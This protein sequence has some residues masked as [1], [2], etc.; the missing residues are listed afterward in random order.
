MHKAPP[1]CMPAWFGGFSA[2]SASR[3]CTPAW[4][5]TARKH[6][7]GPWRG[8]LAHAAL[9]AERQQESPN[10]RFGSLRVDFNRERLPFALQSRR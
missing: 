7:E 8:V 3:T 6:P 4:P 9:I 1:V 5:Q 10:G 2:M